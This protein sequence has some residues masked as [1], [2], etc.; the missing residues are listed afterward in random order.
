MIAAGSVVT[1]DVPPH[2]LMV[3]IPARIKGWVTTSGALLGITV[4]T[5]MNGGTFI[6][7]DT[8]ERVTLE[9]YDG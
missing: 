8:G 7:D 5:G 2:A 9:G 1:K 3:G 4:E 6:C